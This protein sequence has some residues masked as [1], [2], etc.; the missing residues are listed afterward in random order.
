MQEQLWLLNAL[1][2]TLGI[3]WD[4]NRIGY[5][6]GPCS[7]Q[8]TADFMGVRMRV[9]SPRL[10]RRRKIGSEKEQI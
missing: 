4:Q 9:C 7:P 2:H 1:I 10:K 5:T 8:A 3:E 6:L